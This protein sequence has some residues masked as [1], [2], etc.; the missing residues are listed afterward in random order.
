MVVV[1]S[2]NN[3]YESRRNR[4]TWNVFAPPHGIV[5]SEPPPTVLDRL[6]TEHPGRHLDP[7]AFPRKR[8]RGDEARV[9]RDEVRVASMNKK[10]IIGGGC[11]ATTDVTH[12]DAMVRIVANRDHDATFQKTRNIGCSP[13]TRGVERHMLLELGESTGRD[14]EDHW[15]LL[16]L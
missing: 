10:Q 3:I 9:P 6:C 11:T 16:L 8:Q 5:P 1:T 4:A 15:D 14:G 2:H 7:L 13:H 12:Q